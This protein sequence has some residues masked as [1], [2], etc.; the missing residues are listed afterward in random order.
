MAM[1]TSPTHAARLHS[2]ANHRQNAQVLHQICAGF[3][4]FATCLTE[5]R[6]VDGI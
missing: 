5:K 4:V 6:D 3:L 2:F 1:A